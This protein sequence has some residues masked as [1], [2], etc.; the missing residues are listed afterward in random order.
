VTHTLTRWIFLF[1]FLL[2]ACQSGAASPTP[3]FPSPAPPTIAPTL[4]PV[5]VVVSTETATRPPPTATPPLLFPTETPTDTVSAECVNEAAYVGDLTVPDGAQFLPGQP[6][7]KKWSVLNAG[8][9]DW[10]PDYRLVLV[11]GDSLG[12]A[13]ELALYPARA[14][15][16]GVWEIGMT[17]PLAPG[18]YVGRWQA[19]DPQG[20]LFGDVMFIKIEVIPLPVT[21]TPTP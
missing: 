20:N 2:A 14:G 16:E 7:V 18:E 10:G 4:P 21:D 11:S 5:N 9:C 17:A 13:S 12:A 19:R 15:T 1:A 6:L 3:L 8:T